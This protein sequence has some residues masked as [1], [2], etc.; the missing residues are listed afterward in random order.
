MDTM[1]AEW[2]SEWFDSPYYHS[3]YHHRD[4]QE[5]AAFLDALLDHLRPDSDARMLDLACGRGRHARQLS[6]QGFFVT[7]LDISPSNIRHASKLAADNLEFMVHDMRRP[8]RTNYFDQIF[9]FFTSFGY[10]D[11][12]RDHLVT[13][14]HVHSGLK[15]GGS[16]LLDF[17]NSHRVRDSLSPQ[18]VREVD[19]MRFLIE[20]HADETHIFKRIRFEEEG[21]LLEFME[22]VRAFSLPE[23][24]GLLD[25]AGLNVV[26]VFGDHAL[27]P[28][29]PVHSDRLIIHA[30]KLS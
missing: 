29:D 18:E 4:D 2:F 17:M 22:R 23:L 25:Q 5:A 21:R 9:N 15:P 7:G 16:F 26:E 3:L 24:E 10:F 30:R 27:G 19:G 13:L 11:N 1:Q 6:E 14:Q 12:D 20:R 28:W 8:F